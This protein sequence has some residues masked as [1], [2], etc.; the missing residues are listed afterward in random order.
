MTS[1]RA[2]IASRAAQGTSTKPLTD[3]QLVLFYEARSPFSQFHRVDFVV[4]GVTYPSAEH[5]MMASKARLFGDDEAL[6]TILT[7]GTT[8]MKAKA[9]GRRV[10]G[11]SED[12]WNRHKLIIVTEG[13]KAKF[14]QNE[15]LARALL[16]T[17][18]RV[19]AEAS[20]RD[21]VWGIGF[22]AEQPDARLPEMWRGLNLL[23]FVLMDVRAWLRTG[24]SLPPP[25]PP[26]GGH[27]VAQ[28]ADEPIDVQPRGAKRAKGSLPGFSGVTLP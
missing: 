18:D 10:K 11:F 25:S 17:G 12:T 6:K 15:A 14:S 13:N 3:D 8:Q 4:E 16:M 28:T 22:G 1:L 21:M 19:L 23:G 20:P 27:D 5:F 24:R 2:L 9:A 26:S 7:P